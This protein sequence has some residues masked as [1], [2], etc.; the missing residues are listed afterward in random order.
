MRAYYAHVEDAV[1]TPGLPKESVRRAAVRSE[2]PLSDPSGGPNTG[3]GLLPRPAKAS[4][5]GIADT[6]G[7]RGEGEGRERSYAGHP[8]GGGRATV[9]D[10]RGVRHAPSVA[11]SLGRSLTDR[12]FSRVSAVSSCTSIAP[13]VEDSAVS[14]NSEAGRSAET[15][16]TLPDLE[17]TA[18]DGDAERYWRDEYGNG[19]KRFTDGVS[20][21]A[22]PAVVLRS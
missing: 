3:Y 15:I 17:G 12:P 4:G 2:G 10:M 21:S 20:T 5:V 14:G 6:M 22:A 7:R 16:L 9:D 18:V 19:V 1:D 8:A 11:S 13:S